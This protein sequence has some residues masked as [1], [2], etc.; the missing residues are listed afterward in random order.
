MAAR[1][2]EYAAKPQPF[3]G[4]RNRNSFG[5][6]ARCPA[7][8]GGLCVGGKNKDMGKS[9]RMTA[10]RL[11]RRPLQRRMKHFLEFDKRLSQRVPH[12]VFSPSNDSVGAG[13][14]AGPCI[15]FLN[16]HPTTPYG[17]PPTAAHELP[18]SLPICC[19]GRLSWRPA[20]G[21]R[22]GAATFWG[23]GLPEIR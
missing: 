17:P 6:P 11:E 20:N 23:G 4:R 16:D 9:L 18:E 12:Y 22:G 8:T 1:K 14:L 10:G 15:E 3:W 2:W 13:H 19:R 21:I 5:G 7:R